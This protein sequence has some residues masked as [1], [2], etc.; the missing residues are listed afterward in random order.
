MQTKICKGCLKEKDVKKFSQYTTKKGTKLRMGTCNSCYNNKY[1]PWIK[2]P[3][4]ESIY[5]GR[6]TWATASESEK[7]EH[8]KKVFE[9]SVIKKE[10]CWD[11]NGTAHHSGYINLKYDGQRIGLH[12]ISWMI[13]KGPIP[14]DLWVLH[15]CDNRRCSNPEHLYLGTPIN[16]V[17]DREQR[18]KGFQLRGSGHHRAIF[19]EKNV[20]EIK[21]LLNLGVNISKLAKKFN[22]S[23]ASLKYIK[24]EGGW[25]HVKV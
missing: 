9:N 15:H 16:N 17:Q 7:H 10:G 6:F 25:K 24:Y 4:F 14:D 3:L 20:R 22:C 5:D 18:S 8:I 23:P 13:H 12:R 1:Q 2:K 21:K 19:T 11:W